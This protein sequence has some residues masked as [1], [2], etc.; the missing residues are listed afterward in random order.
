MPVN[1]GGSLG[2]GFLQTLADRKDAFLREPGETMET[3]GARGKTD[4]FSHLNGCF[5]KRLGSSEAWEEDMELSPLGHWFESGT[6][7]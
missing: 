4:L 5:Q 3:P 7:C 2:R 6:C 1:H